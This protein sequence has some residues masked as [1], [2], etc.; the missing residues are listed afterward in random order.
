[1]SEPYPAEETNRD[2]DTGSS[3]LNANPHADSNARLCFDLADLESQGKQLVTN[4]LGFHVAVGG[5]QEGLTEWVQ[6]SDEAGV[7]IF[8]KSVGMR[9]IKY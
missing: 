6:R 8:L 2:S 7:P 9:G 4:K 1:V 3:N 5:N